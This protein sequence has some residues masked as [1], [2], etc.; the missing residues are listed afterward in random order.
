MTKSTLVAVV[1]GLGCAGIL[2]ASLLAGQQTTQPMQGHDM[3]GG[4]KSKTMTKAEKIANALTAA[5]ASVSAKATILDWPA[6][7]GAPF[8]VLRPGTNAWKCLPDYAGT[9][10]NDP[11]CLDDT[12]MKWFE[13]YM[14]HKPPVVTRVG[15]GYMMG[16]GGAWMSNSDPYGMTKTADNHWG[17][18]PPHMMIVVPDAAALAGL[19]T[20]PSNGGPYVMLAGTPYAHIMAPTAAAASKR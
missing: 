12:W 10:G 3:P 19:P 1:S 7:E 17:H 2:S 16:A 14:A 13:A 18:H 20:E 15:I 9:D 4:V 11:M 8:E 5:P 6:R